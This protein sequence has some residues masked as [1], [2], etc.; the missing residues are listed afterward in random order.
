MGRVSSD[1]IRVRNYISL[2]GTIQPAV[3]LMI[4]T[5]TGCN[6]VYP[7]Q[8]GGKSG[9]QVRELTIL[10]FL[11]DLQL[12]AIAW[13]KTLGLDSLNAP[14]TLG[15]GMCFQSKWGPP[16][17]GSPPDSFPGKLLFYI[18]CFLL[19]VDTLFI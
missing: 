1:L 9:H 8:V 13:A 4:G 17:D 3:G 15:E 18:A 6:I 5:I 2:A 12:N 11:Q 7:T 19:V 10:P 14:F 16:L